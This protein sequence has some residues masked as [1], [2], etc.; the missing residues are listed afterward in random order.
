MDKV[1]MLRER[2]CQPRESRLKAKMVAMLKQR[3]YSDVRALHPTCQLCRRYGSIRRPTCL[4]EVGA[5]SA[6]RRLLENGRT[7]IGMV[8]VT[9]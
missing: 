7:F 9:G 3:R 5:T 8:R 4:T 2:D 6:S 1:S